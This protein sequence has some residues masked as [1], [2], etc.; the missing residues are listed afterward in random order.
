MGSPKD[1]GITSADSSVS[2]TLTTNS[3]FSS[4]EYESKAESSGRLR[5]GSSKN[6]VEELL[7]PDPDTCEVEPDSESLDP[8]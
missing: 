1:I 4:S 3:V 5:T 8:L 7:K 6:D 2:V